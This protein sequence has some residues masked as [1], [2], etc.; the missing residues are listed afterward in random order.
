MTIQSIRSGTTAATLLAHPLRP[1][2]LAQAR[3]PISASEL[4]RRIG[5]P[6]QR[7]NYHVRQLAG[8]GLLQP[9]G[10]QRKGNMVEQQYVASARAYVL[11]PELLDAAGPHVDD[12]TDTTSAAHLVALCARA[13][14]EVAQVMESA[15]TAGLR[16]RTMSMQSDIRFESAEQRADF[17]RE[18]LSA[19]SDVIARHSSPPGNETRGRPF[20]LLV[21]CYPLPGEV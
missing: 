8:A 12:V 17:T 15:Q 19:V 16:V 4:A 7:I 9:A 10:Q 20:R 18:L 14:S 21:G 1:R 3:E 6:R 11:S 2:I 13:Q 5:Q